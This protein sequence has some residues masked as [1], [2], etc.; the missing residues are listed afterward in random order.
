MDCSKAHFFCTVCPEMSC[1]ADGMHLHL[2]RLCLFAAHQAAMVS[3]ITIILHWSPS[4]TASLPRCFTLAALGLHLPN[5]AV[6]LK[7]YLRLYFLG[8]PNKDI[9]LK[10][11]IARDVLGGSQGHQGAKWLC[12]LAKESCKIDRFFCGVRQWRVGQLP[13]LKKK[14]VTHF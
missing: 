14:I 9:I 8:N 12:L 11:F 1:L 6:A 5:K 10:E 2:D 3:A 4:F 13:P 7:P